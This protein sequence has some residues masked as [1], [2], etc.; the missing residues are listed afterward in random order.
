[1]LQLAD[2]LVRG[3][4][5][6]GL[7]TAIE[8]PGWKLCFDLGTCEDSAVRLGTV[9]FTHAHIDHM[10][11]VVSHCATRD[12]LG[13]SPPRYLVPEENLAAFHDLFA[14]WRRLDHSTLPCEVVGVR[15][16]DR[17]ELGA[18]RWAQVFR[19]IH[20]VPTLGYALCRTNRKLRPELQGAP[21][22]EIAAARARGERIH[23]EEEVVEVAFCG[24]T[25]P[26]VIERE[27]LVREARLLILECTFVGDRVSVAK[28]RDKG[29]IHLDELA[30]RA[31]LLRNE[32]LL[33][34]HFSTRY[35]RSEILGALDRALPAALRARTTAFLPEARGE[36]AG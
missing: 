2:H 1:M 20:R 4:S 32:A 10:G 12:L 35:A 17:V 23:V 26:E 22:P 36:S 11:A 14:A 13:L 24:D 30:A 31:H 25:L 9:L 16:G 8:L 15:P 34:T 28:A 29:H 18:G 33:L 7:R 3:V 27:A 6:G 5:I 21:G 19:A